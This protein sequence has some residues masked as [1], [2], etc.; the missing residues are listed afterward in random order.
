MLSRRFHARVSAVFL[1]L[2]FAVA[3]L[4]ACS[5]AGLAGPETL[6]AGAQAVSAAPSPPHPLPLVRGGADDADSELST[7]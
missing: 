5:D 7:V 1:A 4:V 3:A 2:P 6:G